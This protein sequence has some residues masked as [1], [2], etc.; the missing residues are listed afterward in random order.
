M[1]GLAGTRVAWGAILLKPV[2]RVTCSLHRVHLR[3]GHPDPPRSTFRQSL[4]LGLVFFHQ[5][6]LFASSGVVCWAIFALLSMFCHQ[7][8]VFTFSRLAFSFACC[9]PHSQ[10][11]FSN[12]VKGP[13]DFSSQTQCAYTY[14]P[15]YIPRTLYGTTFTPTVSPPPP[16]SVTPPHHH[17]LP[18]LERGIENNNIHI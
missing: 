17:H 5:T 6:I 3:T 16:R 12:A 13:Q 9:C 8:H 4:L 7:A 15:W 14:R 11:K 10:Q 18:F 1:D 2:C